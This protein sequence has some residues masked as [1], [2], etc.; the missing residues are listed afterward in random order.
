L[1]DCKVLQKLDILWILRREFLRLLLS[2]LRGLTAV[3]LSPG[4]SSMDQPA[5][6]SPA[7]RRLGLGAGVAAVEVNLCLAVDGAGSLRVVE[8]VNET[9]APRERRRR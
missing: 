3:V 7:L 6:G 4:T 1:S 2:I 9:L 5:S 8:V